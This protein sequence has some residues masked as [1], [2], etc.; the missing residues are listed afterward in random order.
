MFNPNSLK[1]LAISIGLCFVAACGGQDNAQPSSNNP[2]P[3]VAASQSPAPTAGVASAA[4]VPAGTYLVGSEM[5]YEPFEFKTKNGEPT[6]F[7]VEL[8]QAIAKAEG[9][10]V[11]FL[12]GK[13]SEFAKLLNNDTH[14]IWA[15]SLSINPER[16]AQVDMSDGF[17]DYEPALFLLDNDKTKNLNSPKDLKGQTIAT[18]AS[19]KSNFAF[20]EEMGATALPVESFYLGIKSL[21]EN[22]AVAYIGDSRVLQYYQNQHSNVKSRLILLGKEKKSLAFAVKKGNT[23]LLGKINSGLAKVKANGELDKLVDKWFGAKKAN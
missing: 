23:E 10:N 20:I 16:L 11:Q 12:H 4:V 8:L 6:G 14:Q 15:S 7:E 3:A 21:H 9:F 5:T 2:P 22:K 1:Y 17:L 19:S 18:H 13:R